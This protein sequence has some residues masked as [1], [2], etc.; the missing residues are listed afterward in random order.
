M[1][2]PSNFII[3]ASRTRAEKEAEVAILNSQAKL[4]AASNKAQGMIAEAEAEMKAVES[5]AEKRR[6]ELEWKR[7]EVRRYVRYSLLWSMTS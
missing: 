4:N 3:P 1:F 7:L 6:F 5:L 2:W